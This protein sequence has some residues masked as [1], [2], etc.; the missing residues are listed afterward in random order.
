MT[1]TQDERASSPASNLLRRRGPRESLTEHHS[2]TST[3]HRFPCRSSLLARGQILNHQLRHKHPSHSVARLQ[4]MSQIMTTIKIAQIFLGGE[5]SLRLAANN[6]QKVAYND[7]Y[8]ESNRASLSL[9]EET[10]SP[11]KLLQICFGNQRYVYQLRSVVSHQA[12]WAWQ[13]AQ[14]HDRRREAAY[15]PFPRFHFVGVCGEPWYVRHSTPS[16][17]KGVKDDTSSL[18]THPHCKTTAVE[19][20]MVIFD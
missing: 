10:L 13:V 6:P 12:A 20:P 9:R 5:N 7:R 17:R 1:S 16:E 4:W 3:V 2:Y 8:P 18:V 14:T 19:S 11:D 15:H